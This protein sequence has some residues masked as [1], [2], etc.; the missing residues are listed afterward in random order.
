MISIIVQIYIVGLYLE[1]CIQSIVNQFFKNIEIFLVNDG[2]TD[3]SPKKI[4]MSGNSEIQELLLFTKRTVVCQVQEIPASMFLKER[5]F[6]L[7]ILMIG[8]SRIS[9][10]SWIMR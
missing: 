5:N 10:N 2:S 8:L 6:A 9:L 3:S 7:L 4:V 1:R